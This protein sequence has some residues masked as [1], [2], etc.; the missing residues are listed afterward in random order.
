MVE[1]SEEITCEIIFI[2]AY[3]RVEAFYRSCSS[4]GVGNNLPIFFYNHYL[5]LQIAVNTGE[6]CGGR[7]Y[8]RGIAVDDAAAV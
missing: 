4:V 8:G 1:G 2:S 5:A 7:L 3:G 6:L